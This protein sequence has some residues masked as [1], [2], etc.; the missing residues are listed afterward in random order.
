MIFLVGSTSSVE[1]ALAL[2]LLLELAA[3][4]LFDLLLLL[5]LFKD[6]VSWGVIVPELCPGI[7]SFF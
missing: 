1:A 6:Q 4:L 2:L 7:S 3:V 5:L